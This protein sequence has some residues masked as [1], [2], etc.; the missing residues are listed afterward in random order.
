LRLGI[1]AVLRQSIKKG[2][3]PSWQ[4]HIQGVEQQLKFLESVGCYGQRGEI[5]PSLQDALREIVSNVNLDVVPAEVWRTVI[6]P[7]KQR[8]QMSWRAFSGANNLEYNGSALMETGI[9]RER[10]A[11]F[12]TVLGDPEMRNLSQSG[13]FWDEITAIEPLGVEDVY[14]ATVPGTH[15]FVTNDIIV[16]NSIEQDAD[17]VMFIYREDYYDRETERKNITDILIRKHRNGPIGEAELHFRAEQSRFFDVERKS[18]VHQG[19]E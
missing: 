5:I 13:V 6:S 17:V 19:E 12:A 10:L 2:Y 4:V 14:D 11:K 3:R 7:A 15:N 18:K 16:H 8:A 9:G 1:N